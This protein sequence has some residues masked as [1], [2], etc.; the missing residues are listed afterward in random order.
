MIIGESPSAATFL[1]VQQGFTNLTNSEGKGIEVALTELDI[2]AQTMPPTD[3]MQIQ[4]FYDYGNVTLGCAMNPA[5]VGITLWDFDDTY[6]CESFN[7]GELVE[8][9]VLT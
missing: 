2:R 6:S 8:V 5:C 3:Q 7:P 1:G 9:S 4:Q